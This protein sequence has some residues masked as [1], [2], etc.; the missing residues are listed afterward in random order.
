[1]SHCQVLSN[2]HRLADTRVGGTARK[3]WPITQQPPTTPDNGMK[4]ALQ[5]RR[6][7]VIMRYLFA[8]LLGVPFG[9]VVLWFLFSHA[10]K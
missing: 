2:C 10:C 5:W 8:W 3:V 7:F 6:R 9:L 4:T 1:M